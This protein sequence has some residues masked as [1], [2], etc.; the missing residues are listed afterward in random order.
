MW[1]SAFSVFAVISLEVQ[2]ADGGFKNVSGVSAECTTLLTLTSMVFGH[3][4]SSLVGGVWRRAWTVRS[5]MGSL[6]S[7][8]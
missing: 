8:G 6:T 4:D 7:G 5:G 2:G 1:M 3:V